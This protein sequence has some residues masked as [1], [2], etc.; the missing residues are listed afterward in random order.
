MFLVE[1]AMSTGTA[2]AVYSGMSIGGDGVA[3]L[4]SMG[5]LAY[6]L[7]VVII[8]LVIVLVAS[9]IKKERR[10]AGFWTPVIIIGLMYQWVWW[11]IWQGYMQYLQTGETSY[12]LGF[13]TPSAWMV[14]GIWTC[15]FFLM[16][17]YVVGFRKFIFSEADEE[18][19]DRLL[20]DVKQG[21]LETGGEG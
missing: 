12:T 21:R 20:E 10:K 5:S 14:Y 17:F 19:Y 7:Q 4:R 13:T 1:P 15:G 9:G 2:H 8:T 3:R 16:V 18:K 6:W 11:N